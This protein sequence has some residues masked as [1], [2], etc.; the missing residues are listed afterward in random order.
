MAGVWDNLNRTGEDKVVRQWLPALVVLLALVGHGARAQ[1]PGL[2]ATVEL[3]DPK[4][5]RV[6]ADP[7]NLPFS[8]EAG[9]G[10]ENRIATL[11]GRE[12]GKPVAYTYYPQV[13]GFVRNTLNMFRCDVVMGAA[14]G[15]D[16]VQTTNSYYRTVYSLLIRPGT[17]LDGIESLE[18]P[19]LKN[20][21]IGIVA[22]T[23]PA[24][25]MAA[26]GLMLHAKP[27]ALTVDTRYESPA[28]DMADDLVTG[29]ID[30]GVLWGP[31]AGY[32]AK[33]SGTRLTVVP[34]LKE[35]GVRMDFRIALGVRH[36]DQEWKRTLNRLIKEN[37]SE[38]DSIL[39]EYGVPL[40]DEHGAL[41]PK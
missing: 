28:K 40:L 13:I 3:V 21:R 27:Y 36:S 18:D 10:F 19:R 31:I 29:R 32:W 14:Q 6:C 15:D 4:V 30:A 33:H 2:G 1:S 26:N 41:I 16:L 8:N 7:R 23:P 17:G 34:L 39:E 37:Q 38:I 22:G 12:L 24:T 25:L 9:E 5:L 35:T 11:L 20:M